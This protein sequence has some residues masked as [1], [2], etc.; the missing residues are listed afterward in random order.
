MCQVDQDT[1]DRMFAMLGTT[2][3]APEIS[4]AVGLDPQDGLLVIKKII[5][6]RGTPNMASL[7]RSIDRLAAI[8]INR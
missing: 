2:M 1:E 4:R 8:K 5:T 3:T 6:E 7:K